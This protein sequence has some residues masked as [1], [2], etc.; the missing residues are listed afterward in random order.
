MINMK[1]ILPQHYIV[2]EGNNWIR[3]KS[4][5]GLRTNNDSDDEEAWFY[6][7]SAI[8]NKYKTLKE[9]YHNTCAYYQ[10]FTVYI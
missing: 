1:D 7:F 5:I 6:T 9:V 10:D 8:K 2:T 4:R 3:C